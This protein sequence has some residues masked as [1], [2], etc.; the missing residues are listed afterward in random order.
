MAGRRLAWTA[1]V[2]GIAALSVAA[3]PS[4]GG[5]K[6]PVG[7][8]KPIYV[9]KHLAGGEPISFYDRAHQ[10][11]IY[12]SHEG[13]THTLHDGVGG[14]PAQ[15]ADFAAN[16]RNQ[17]N[18]WTSRNGRTWSRVDLDGTGFEA[19]P[20]TNQGFSDPDLTQD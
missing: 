9:D 5:G 19:D 16:Y 12:S 10:T 14:A 20:Q 11:Y 2:A 15:T 3:A 4:F 8:A 17:V 13:T 1:A 6:A 18:I 7:F